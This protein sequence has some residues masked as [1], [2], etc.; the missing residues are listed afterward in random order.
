MA[1]QP[2]GTR[3]PRWT[4]HQ[5]DQVIGR[6]LQIGVLVAA[7]VT[8]IAGVLYLQQNGAATPDYQTFRGVP[9]TLSSLSGILHGVM[10]GRRA[11]MVQAGLV[12]LI[13]TPMARVAL[14]LGAFL[15]QRDRLYVLLTTIVLAVLVYGLFWAHG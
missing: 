3:G 11:A 14:T 4:D 13:L 2:G 9:A 5:I 8:I 1:P 6:L 10:A 7:V 15:V 12:L